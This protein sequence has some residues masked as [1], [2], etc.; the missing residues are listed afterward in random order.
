MNKSIQFIIL[1]NQMK[2]LRSTAMNFRYSCASIFFLQFN[3]LFNE[4]E[5]HFPT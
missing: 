2:N 1:V 4:I 5:G 3:K